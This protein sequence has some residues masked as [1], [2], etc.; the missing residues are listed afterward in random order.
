MFL[1]PLVWSLATVSTVLALIVADSQ[2]CICGCLPTQT[3]FL[4]I[5]FTSSPLMTFALY[6][7]I[8]PSKS[9]LFASG[10][11]ILSELSKSE[12]TLWKQWALELI[13]WVTELKSCIDTDQR[14]LSKSW[15]VVRESCSAKRSRK[16]GQIR[17]EKLYDP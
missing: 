5:A 9:R 2:W 13:N 15:W 11:D 10:T 4:G 6:E 7:W 16:V 8:N 17:E 3:P 14:L 1:K 12:L